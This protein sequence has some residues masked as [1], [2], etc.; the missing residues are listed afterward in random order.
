MLSKVVKVIGITVMIVIGAITIGIVDNTAVR[1]AQVYQIDNKIVTFE[2]SAGNLW[3]WF[4]EE[5]ESFEKGQKVTLIMDTNKTI[6][7]A[8]DDVILKIRL[9]K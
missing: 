7:T 9:D 3:D 1:D 4:I 2:D 6:D 8:E 5:E